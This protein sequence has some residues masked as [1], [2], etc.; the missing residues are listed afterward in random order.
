MC[1]RFVSASSPDEIARYFDAEAPEALLEPSYNVA[2]TNDVYAVLDDGG[3]RRL[4]AFH[5]GLVPIWAKD[6]RQ[7]SKMINARAETLAAKNAYKP[8]FKRRRCIIPADGFYEWKKIPGQKTK[9]PHFIHRPDGE[10]LA[11]AGLW[12][13]W[14][15]PDKQGDPLRSCTIVTTSAN[16]TMQPLHDRMPVILPASA[17][18]EWL[19]PANDDIDTLGKLL[20]PAPPELIVTHPV[21]TEVNS[22]RNKGAELI[23]PVEPAP[24][25]EQ[26]EL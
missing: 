12:E 24:E 7:G 2:P 3:V 8:A 20:V 22:V 26:Q 6:P 18:E 13:V 14:R 5:W 17:W 19:D 23:E 11:F 10:P 16:E 25:A 21:S 9:Q 15:G 4:D 1:G